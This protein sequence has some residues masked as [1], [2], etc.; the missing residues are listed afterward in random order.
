MSVKTVG[1]TAI[2]LLI[3]SGFATARDQH[4]VE[5]QDKK[6]NDRLVGLGRNKL[7]IP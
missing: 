7:R 1:S 6:T 5:S 4:Y 3:A 2:V